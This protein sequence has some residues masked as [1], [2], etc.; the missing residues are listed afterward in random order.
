MA[1]NTQADLMLRRNNEAYKATEEL[2]KFFQLVDSVLLEIAKQFSAET[3]GL[4]K[5]S[6]AE[7]GTCQ[8][9]ITGSA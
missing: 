8:P 9:S 7:S 5:S 6:S 3:P 4:E 1:P 2:Q